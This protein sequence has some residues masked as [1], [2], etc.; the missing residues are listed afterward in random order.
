MTE[1]VLVNRSVM[2]YGGQR[3]LVSICDLQGRRMRHQYV[4]H[5]QMPDGISSIKYLAS[6]SPHMGSDGCWQ[7]VGALPENVMTLPAVIDKGKH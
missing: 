1:I 4:D 6:W 7:L 3:L 2:F 5:D